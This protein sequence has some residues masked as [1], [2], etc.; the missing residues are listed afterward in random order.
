MNDQPVEIFED[1]RGCIGMA[2]TL[3]S[4]RAK[5]IDIKHH[6]IRDNIEKGLIKLKAISSENQV[7][8]I[9]TK[10]LD[11]NRFSTLCLKLGLQ[12]QD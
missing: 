4:K 8:D 11:V 10:S 2:N 5:H 12:D 3:E 6:F 7:A 1:N 9:F